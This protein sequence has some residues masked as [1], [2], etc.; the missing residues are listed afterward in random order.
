M[1]ETGN[2]QT[3]DARARTVVISSTLGSSPL[4]TLVP[5]FSIHSADTNVAADPTD[6]ADGDGDGGA[7]A[8]GQQDAG[9]G[10]RPQTVKLNWNGKPRLRLTQREFDPF[11]AVQGQRTR[12]KLQHARVREWIPHCLLIGHYIPV[13]AL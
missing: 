13:I 2:C 9:G 1:N 11:F 12:N 4:T 3:V 7:Q 6:C 8:G 10:T 5:C